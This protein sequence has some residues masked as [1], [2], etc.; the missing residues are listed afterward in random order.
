MKKLRL[1]AVFFDR[2]YCLLWCHGTQNLKSFLRAFCCCCYCCFLVCLLFMLFRP[3]FGYKRRSVMS[4]RRSTW[5]DAVDLHGAL[6]GSM[7]SLRLT[8]DFTLASNLMLLRGPRNREE[9]D[10]LSA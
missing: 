5:P 10:H 9:E 1:T 6:W 3:A 8:A 4:G 2:Q 7:V